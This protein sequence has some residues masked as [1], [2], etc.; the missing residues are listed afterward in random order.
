MST[1]TATF[2]EELWAE[3]RDVRLKAETERNETKKRLLQ[4]LMSETRKQAKHA[5]KKGEDKCEIHF[6]TVYEQ[7]PL[8]KDVVVTSF[9]KELLALGFN[10]REVVWAFHEVNSSDNEKGKHLILRLAW[11]EPLDSRSVSELL[12]PPV[13]KA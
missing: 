8:H 9:R 12:N 5:T 13:E 10:K 6:P 1:V 4:M 3:A 11:D 7:E 2:A